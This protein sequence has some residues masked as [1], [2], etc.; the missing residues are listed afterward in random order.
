MAFAT[1]NPQSLC[2]DADG[3]IQLD[4]A[5]ATVFAISLGKRPPFVSQSTMQSGA[6]LLRRLPVARGVF[7]FVRVTI[8][9]YARVVDDFLP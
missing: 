3:A 2:V 1:P 9:S 8:K 5:N 4:L 7:G 6:R